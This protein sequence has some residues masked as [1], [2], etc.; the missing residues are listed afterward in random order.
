MFFLPTF[1]KTSQLIYDCVYQ[2]SR[3]TLRR[4]KVD[5]FLFFMVPVLLIMWHLLFMQKLQAPFSK[6]WLLT[7]CPHLSSEISNSSVGWVSFV[8]WYNHQ[9]FRY[10][11]SLPFFSA[12]KSFLHAPGRS[13]YR[14]I[15]MSGEN[16]T[17]KVVAV[18]GKITMFKHQCKYLY[19][20]TRH[21]LTICLISCRANVVEASLQCSNVSNN[22]SCE[23]TTCHFLHSRSNSGC[24]IVGCSGANKHIR[25]L[26]LHYELPCNR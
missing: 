16:I 22:T 18:R 25:S 21:L 6:V 24:K 8:C 17:P 13:H 1:S 19:S 12:F 4:K 10:S 2:C 20:S 3:L 14:D 7:F 9:Q 26:K 23:Q 15:P 5:I 11:I